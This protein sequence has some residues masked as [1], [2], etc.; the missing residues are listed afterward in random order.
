MRVKRINHIC[1]AVQSL[2]EARKYWEPVLGKEGPDELYTHEPE[3]IRVARYVLGESALELVESTS[4]DG[5]VAKWIR[6]R[7][8]GLMILSLHVQ[9]TRDA[10]E[11]LENMNYSIVKDKQG[12]KVRPFRGSD[13]AFVH[14]KSLNNVLVEIIDD[15]VNSHTGEENCD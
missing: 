7:G 8:E 9:K 10:V 2:D 4:E 14:P 6:K 15:P 1:V 3:Q 11:E 5:P 13:F 12:R